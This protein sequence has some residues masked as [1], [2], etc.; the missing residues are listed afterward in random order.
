MGQVYTSCPCFFKQKEGD[1]MNNKLSKAKTFLAALIS[2]A[3][4]GAVVFG[5]CNKH[6]SDLKEKENI[7]QEI[8]EV[9]DY[10]DEFFL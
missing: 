3:I 9:K 6:F 10:I 5:L 8:F 2:S 1:K 7:I 4:T